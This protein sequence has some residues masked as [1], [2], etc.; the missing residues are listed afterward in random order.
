[1]AFLLQYVRSYLDPGRSSLAEAHGRGR[2][3]LGPPGEAAVAEGGGP[4]A[5]RPAARGPG[6]AEAQ[7]A[8]ARDRGAAEAARAGPDD[9]AR[10]RAR[11]GV[12]GEGVAPEEELPPLHLPLPLRHVLHVRPRRH[13]PPRRRLYGHGWLF[14]GLA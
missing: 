6:E 10:A 4:A 3:R 7:A 12:A 9:T 13:R 1:L 8:E 11:G 5:A 14:L 2:R